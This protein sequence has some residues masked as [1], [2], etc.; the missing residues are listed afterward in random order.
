MS[1][2]KTEEAT[3]HRLR[4]AR[5]QGNVPRSAEL[6]SALGVLATVGVLSLTGMFVLGRLTAHLS[7]TLGNLGG[8]PQ[9]VAARAGTD[10]LILLV[11]TVGPVLLAGTLAPVA[12]HLGL[13]GPIWSPASLS[14]NPSRLNPLAALRRW[15]SARMLVDLVRLCLKA[16][17]LGWLCQDFFRRELLPLAA[18]VP[19]AAGVG[20]W[21]TLATGFA[22]RMVVA[23]LVIGVADAAWQWWDH[24]RSLRMSRY[25]VRQEYKQQEGDPHRKARVRQMQ[26]KL[27]K[28]RS[29]EGV[30]RARVV[31]TNP[32][33]LAVALEYDLSMPAPRVVAKGADLQAE[34]LKKLARNLGV[35]VVEDRSLA[36]ALYPLDLE[37]S[38]PPALYRAVAEVLLS[39]SRAED[40]L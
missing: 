39:V 10:I 32:T 31:I 14:L 13:A 3:S 9:K 16:A 18:A 40:Y 20:Q 29:L 24:R 37:E 22:W 28:E 27:A 23:Q 33:H 21:L 26:R 2:E 25:E 6:N 19:S 30:K 4:E 17:V 15:F 12:G 35:P 11:A 5:L 38:V 36:R 8:D 7:D 34:R 1:E